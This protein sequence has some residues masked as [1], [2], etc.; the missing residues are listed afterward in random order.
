MLQEHGKQI[1]RCENNTL[2][3]FHSNAI[4]PHDFALIRPSFKQPLLDLLPLLAGYLIASVINRLPIPW[5]RAIIIDVW[6]D[7]T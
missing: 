6:W 2:T 1:R 5:H 4:L 3:S 7:V